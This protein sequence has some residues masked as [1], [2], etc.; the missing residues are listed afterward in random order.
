MIMKKS[1]YL[2]IITLLCLY[3][4][5]CYSEE[6]RAFCSQVWQNG[7][8]EQVEV[9]TKMNLTDNSLTLYYPHYIQLK[10]I[11]PNFQGNGITSWIFQDTS[12]KQYQVNFSS[13][14]TN[15]DYNIVNIYDVKTGNPLWFYIITY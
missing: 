1:L 11:K 4:L 8:R 2:I 15:P 3:P 13:H 9:H 14:P 10:K 12:G 5:K 7:E 6:F